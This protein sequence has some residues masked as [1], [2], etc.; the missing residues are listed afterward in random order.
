MVPKTRRSQGEGEGI[1]GKERGGGWELVMILLTL[2]GVGKGTK[3]RRGGPVTI[4][5]LLTMLAEN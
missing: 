5:P 4:S 2:G 1:L 3:K